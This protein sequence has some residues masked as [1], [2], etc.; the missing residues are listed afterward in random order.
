M[1]K[2]KK[3][4]DDFE[5]EM[6]NF[7]QKQEKKQTLYSNR[8]YRVAKRWKISLKDAQYLIDTVDKA[9]SIN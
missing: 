8:T 3:S 4:S 6:Y 7:N 2:K 5:Y 1:S 9:Q